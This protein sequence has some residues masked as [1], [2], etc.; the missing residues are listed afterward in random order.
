MNMPRLSG[1]ERVILTLL[2]SNGEM[3]GLAMVHQSEALKRGTVYVTLSRMEDKG[4]V[5]SRDVVGPDPGPAR[6]MYTVTG[7][8]KRVLAFADAWD[9]GIVEGFAT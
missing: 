7:L 3:Y 4:F 6:R 2:I 8:G 5:K 1:K 9:A